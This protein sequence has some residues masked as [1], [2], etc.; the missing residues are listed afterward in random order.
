[1]VAWHARSLNWARTAVGVGVLAVLAAC[2]GGGGGSSSTSGGGGGGGSASV[3]GVASK[4]LLLNALVTA[5]AV[6]SDGSRGA[7]LATTSTSATDGSYTLS[8]LPAGA[9]VLLEVTPKATG[10]KMIDE[11]TNAEVDVPASSGFKLRAATSL[12]SSGTTSAQITPF[13]DMAVKLAEDNNNGRLS[14][15]VVTAANGSVSAFVGISVLTESPSFTSEGGNVKPTNAAGAKLA[16]ISKMADDG[17]VGDCG[18]A[19]GTLAKVKCVVEYL[20]TQGTTSDV[21]TK[22]NTA[23]TAVLL[24][25]A[26]ISNPLEQAK[27]ETESVPQPTT[28]PPVAAGTQTGVQEAKALIRSVRTTAAALSNQSDSQS[29]A[30]R[31]QKMAESAQG[32][33]QPL[34]DGTVRAVSAITEALAEHGAIVAEGAKVDGFTLY[35]YGWQPQMPYATSQ[36]GSGCRFF[37]DNNFDT[38]AYTVVEGVPTLSTTDF[39]A[40]RVLQQVV[41][42]QTSEGYYVPKYAVFNRV[43]LSKL[44]STQFKVESI[45][46][47]A[48][49]IA[50]SIPVM[51]GPFPSMTSTTYTYSATETNV[52][53]GLVSA[54]AT[55]TATGW[56]LAG[57]LAPGVEKTWTYNADA[58][59][60]EEGIKVLGTKQTVA[61]SYGDTVTVATQTT[62]RALTGDVRVY[63]GANVQSRLSLLA[64]SYVEAQRVFT[65][66]GPV[67]GEMLPKAVHLVMEGQVKSGFKINGTLDMSDF[68]MTD[69]RWG[70]SRGSFA[71]SFTDVDGVKLFDGTLLSNVPNDSGAGA[72]V[73][74]DGVLTT[75]G[76]N[77]LTVR[78]TAAQSATVS[79]D[80]TVTGRY[81][82]GTTTFL[83]TVFKS[84]GAP[85]TDSISFQTAAG[86]VGFVAKPSDTRVDIKKGDAVVGV[87]NVS[88]GRL[89]Y[90]DGSYEQF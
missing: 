79:G 1:M 80:Y 69:A 8:G 72:S 64:G 39:M 77:T 45:V 16:A 67:G 63:A 46:R 88:T 49:I 56:S 42:G 32:V 37:T 11:T 22:L 2:G 81:T 60:H 26:A 48:D 86:G 35:G 75:T 83:V 19:S 21:A 50:T 55:R 51:I 57:D 25:D 44:N 68:L 20:A 84:E 28:L 61:L 5:Y 74:L 76:S 10:T 29:L 78:L 40:C 36:I 12:E 34:D 85:D 33:A 38:P 62:R 17:A 41:W 3:S 43:R 24:N 14:A 82:Q 89:V 54:T 66:A 4:G 71:G 73:T 13:T 59:R 65:V 31:V 9:L 18:S 70:F 47:K 58:G 6:N 15:D 27:A 23:T 7:V 87:F 30:Y 53:S 90:A 52:S